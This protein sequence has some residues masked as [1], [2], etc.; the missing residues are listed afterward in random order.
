[1]LDDIIKT[2]QK[3][4]MDNVLDDKDLDNNNIMN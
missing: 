3:N 4:E 2:G 1:M